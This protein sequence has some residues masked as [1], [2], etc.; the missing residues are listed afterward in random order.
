MTLDELANTFAALG[1]KAAYNLD[2]GATAAMVFE[3]ALVNQPTNGGRA[4]SDIICF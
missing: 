3:G 2:G 1:C 4:S